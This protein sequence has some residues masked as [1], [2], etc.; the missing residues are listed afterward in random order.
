MNRLSQNI[1]RL[2]KAACLT[3]EQLAAELG[4]TPQSVSNWE[5]GGA[6]D[7]SMLPVLANFFSVTIDEL[8]ENDQKSV[9]EQK[10]AFWR[11][12]ASMTEPEQRLHRLLEEYRRFPNDPLLLHRLIHTLPHERKENIV[13]IEELSMKLLAVTADPDLRESVISLMARLSRKEDRE[14]WLSRLPRRMLCR[15]QEIRSRC[16]LQDGD[17]VGAAILAAL[18]NGEDL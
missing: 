17:A 2:R 12:L 9:R 7:I 18:Q 15:Q 10:R 14:N 8:M 4:V 3:Q 5:R 11:E 1:L 16:L 13:F 6:P